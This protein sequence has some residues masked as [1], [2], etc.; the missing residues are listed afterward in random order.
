MS[1]TP[2][3]PEASPD[4]HEQPS[5][6]SAPANAPA[7]QVERR[8]GT[9]F[10]CLHSG[11]LT[12][13]PDQWRIVDANPAAARIF[14]R[15]LRE[16]VG[17]D[18][19]QFIQIPQADD[20]AADGDATETPLEEEELAVARPDGEERCVL[21]SAADIAVEGRPLI[22][23]SL[24]DVTALRREEEARAMLATAAESAAEA[25][26]ITAPDGT[27]RYVNPAFEHMTGHRHEDVLG[28]HVGLL[29]SGAHD[30]AF[31]Q[32]MVAELQQGN[33]W[34]GK[35]TNRKKDGTL[36]EAQATIAPL[37]RRDG[38]VTGFVE[39]K[40]DITESVQMAER[41][42][43]TQ[44]MEAI[45]NLAGGVAHDFNNMLMVITNYAEFIRDDLDGEHPL[46][47]DVE[48]ILNAAQ[49]AA[50]LTRQLLAFSRR[51][52]IKPQ[53][54]DLNEIVSEM[55]KMLR[56][57][58]GE[59]IELQVCPDP[60]ISL[61]EVDAG[62][63]EQVLANL[64]VNARDATQQGGNITIQT[65]SVALDDA[66][67]AAYI[68]GYAGQFTVLIVSDSGTGMSEDVRDRVFE[69]FFTTKEKG[70]GTGLGLAMVY[71]IVKQHKGFIHLESKVGYGTSFR[72]FLPAAQES[73][74]QLGPEDDVEIL[75]GGTETVLVVEDEV[76]VRQI[77][78][79]MLQK[80]GYEVLQ[81]ENGQA[82]LQV[83]M[84]HRDELSLVL[85]DV[86]MPE[87]GGKA[88]ADVLAQMIP[89]IRVV[90]VSGYP[91]THLSKHWRVPETTDLLQKPFT[92]DGL[93]AVARRAL[94]R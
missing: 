47:E 78:V 67:A 66:D 93:A 51:Q 82:A 21:V 64:V 14:G 26:I 91:P 80:L 35:L 61:V 57:L 63:I 23:L 42:R 38:T 71:G 70:S 29:S 56:R 90:Y 84:E 24:A 39:V 17:Q 69:P 76:T 25:I 41:L 74:V 37:C 65:T 48:Q 19:R 72:I 55:Q 50:G 87:M 81:A 94:E 30:K 85:T 43:Q 4:E 86:V 58:I 49:R 20:G 27:I 8:L 7:A 12:V 44:K 16:L 40:H 1:N 88:L 22:L 9:I 6:G 10:E 33:T 68:D 11:V 15:E 5:P 45:G 52:V 13:A 34:S 2:S 77:M 18:V 60:G 54:A 46:Q 79:N 62:Q 32:D 89:G 73:D 92:I 31:Y 3:P 53:I 59:D 83:A 28:E 36:Y 75:I